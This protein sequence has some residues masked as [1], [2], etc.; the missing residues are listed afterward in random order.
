MFK[1]ILF[2]VLFAV[3]IN[4]QSPLIHHELNVVIKPDMSL[5]EVTDEVTIDK[6][7]IKDGLQFKL[8]NALSVE[9]SEMITKL[10]KQVDAEDIGMDLDDSGTKSDLKLNVYAI[11]FSPNN[12][13]NLKLILKYKG[14]IESPVKQSKENYAR[15]FS[16]SPGIIWEKGVYLAG[17]TYW[18]P[19]FGD[20]L[21]SF[22][23]T[24]TLP[25]SWKT[26]S[27]GTRTLDEKKNGQ[28]IDKWESPTPQEEIFLIAAPFQE[29]DYPMG[30]VTAYAF[31]RTPD[32]ALANKYLE[33]TA[34]YME[35]YRKLVGPFPYTKFALVENFWETGY[36]MPSFT[37]LGEKIIRLPFILHSS[38]PHELLHNYWGNSVYVDFKSGNWCEGLTAYMA[39]HLIKEQR[40]QAV[41]YRSETLQKFTDY[42]TLENDFPLSKFSSRFDPPSEAIGYGKTSM[43]FHMLRRKVGDE[44]FIKS[45]QVFNRNNKFK[46]SSFDDIRKAFEEVTGKD[47][48]WFFDQWVNRTGAPQLV[49]EDVQVNS[50]RGSNNVSFTLKQIQPEEVFYL[51]VPVVIITKDG[52]KTETVEMNEKESKYNFTVDSA[53]LKILV[54]PEF[55]LM[56]KLDPRESPPTFTK[57]F[58]SK[59]SL[60]ILPDQNDA[61][62]QQYKDFVE[63]WIK[64]N[65]NKFSVKSQ[66]Q[67]KEL[68]DNESVMLLGT[69]NKFNSVVNSELKKYNSEILN[70]G[71]KFGKREIPSDDNSFFI[72]VS[73]P[74]NIKEVITL[75]TIGNKSAVEGLNDKLP[76]Y[77][78]YSYLAFNGSEPANIE[79]GVWQ[80][81]NSPMFKD[82][83]SADN[84]I[85]VKLETR[86]ALAS[87]EP[88]FSAE[89]MMETVKFLASE[90]LKGR[91]IGTP[92]LDIA[93]DYIAKKFE[94]YGLLPGSDDGTYFQSWKQDVLDK[95][96]ISLKNIIGIIPGTNPDLSEAVVISAHY[97]HLG[98]GWP[99]VKKGNEGK[100]H[101]GAD[102]NA[103]GVSVLLELAKSLGKSFKPAR[104]IIFVAFTAEEAG[105]IGS[106]YFVTNYKKYPAR[107]IFAILNLDTVGRLFGNKL[108]VLNTNTAREW[109]FIFMGANFTTGVPT[110]LV[111][112]DLDASDQTAFIEKGIPGVQLFYT[113]IKSDYHSPEDIADKID[114]DG[115][116]KTAAISREVLEYLAD[117]TEPMPFT[118]TQGETNSTTKKNS[119]ERNAS[120]GAMPDFTFNGE[121]VKI[122]DVADN[123]PAANAGLQK[124]DVIIGF[125]DKPVKNLTE[126][127]NYLKQHKPG[128]KVKLTIIR[129]NTKQD[130]S[131]TLSE[132]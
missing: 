41:E 49:L 76:H 132:R 3:T 94:E 69:K 84:N 68:P 128:D 108:M 23:L 103:S 53:P 4:A 17:S 55:D 34:Q 122:A 40:G 7:L 62:Y 71:I 90:D 109:K 26:V 88:V 114:V 100:I 28:H 39:D 72:S 120:T 125:D 112:Q 1:N 24:T 86:K 8:H 113:G 75:L 58:G 61:S 47:W 64:G 57:A 79:K 32:E 99:D 2:F 50:V 11:K 43:V 104:T 66:D 56:R 83:A 33:A 74:K 46:R 31:L 16:E 37:L 77:A 123:S 65:E 67:V 106:R 15:G 51:D 124:G 118:G 78:K 45:F 10:D 98:L 107:K 85:E 42:V 116:I 52:I 6:S 5:L 129:N 87:L 20:E 117:R 93:A 131:I 95:K 30:S 29:Y 27:V 81:I 89:R 9:P 59:K 102:D 126:Y 130:V 92:E 105:L 14:K 21:V 70:N 22:N 63:L 18:V 119:G 80:V 91:G 110:E 38:Y 101:Y 97:D 36:G 48:K 127:S 60:I 35:M 96:N 121:G 54:D 19:Y 82:I 73:N 44:Q 25:D 13:G 12:S 115:L 111:T